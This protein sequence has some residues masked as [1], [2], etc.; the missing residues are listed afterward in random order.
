MA[1]S[2]PSVSIDVDLTRSTSGVWLVKM[3]KYLSQILNEYGDGAINGEVGR[4]VKRPPAPGSKPSVP[5]PPG[6]RS[7]EVFF[8]LNDQIMEKLR[9]KNPSKDYQLPPREHRFC[10]SNISDG[11]LRTVYTRTANSATG[12]QI[13]LAGKVIQRAEVRPVENAQYM[14]MKRKQFQTYQEPARRAQMIK[15]KTNAYMPKRDHESNRLLKQ[16][17]KEMGKRV[18]DSEDDVLNRIFSAFSKNQYISMSGLETITQQPKNY[19]VQLVKRYCNYNKAV[20]I[21]CVISTRL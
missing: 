18:R 1:A 15:K 19:L 4:L 2:D 13:A 9:E 5:A 10:L 21:E 7:Q 6:G 17:K 11:V 8:C 14:S 12:E 20:G 3:P 16:R